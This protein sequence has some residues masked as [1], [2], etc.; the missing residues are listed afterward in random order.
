MAAIPLH[1]LAKSWVNPGNHVLLG[2]NP[3]LGPWPPSSPPLPRPLPR[4]LPNPLPYYCYS[5]AIDLF[6]IFK[7]NFFGYLE[8]FFLCLFSYL[9]TRIIPH[10]CAFLPALSFSGTDPLQLKQSI[11]SL[12][13]RSRSC[14]EWGCCLYPVS[15]TNSEPYLMARHA[16][17]L[18]GIASSSQFIFLCISDR[19]C[20]RI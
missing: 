9:T 15:R 11:N 17:Y 19:K 14:N 12:I 3:G 18:V 13:S 8:F 6:W 10:V 16:T 20:V 5:S 2:L 1:L 7:I 4:P